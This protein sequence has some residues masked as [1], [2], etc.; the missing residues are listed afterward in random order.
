MKTD[1]R[2]AI[3][4]VAVIDGN[5]GRPV[6]DQAVII[7][8]E[9]IEKVCPAEEIKNDPIEK[10]SLPGKYVMPGLMCI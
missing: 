9:R 2:F 1:K 4:D 6:P 10:I 7:N 8:G 3:T 5:G